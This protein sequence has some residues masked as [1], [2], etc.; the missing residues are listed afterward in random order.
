LPRSKLGET[1]D[2]NNKI[3]NENNNLKDAI[4]KLC[5]DNEKLKKELDRTNIL[6]DNAYAIF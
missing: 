5:K 1:I 2:A 3:V 6:S 4:E